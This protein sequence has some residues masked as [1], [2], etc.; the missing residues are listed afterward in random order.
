MTWY[1]RKN[2][3]YGNNDKLPPCRYGF[4]HR[5]KLELAVCEMLWLHEKAGEW[6]HLGHEVCIYLTLARHKY[7]A[8][9]HARDLKTGQD[10]YLEA[11]GFANARWPTTVKLY[12]FYG[13]APL[14]VWKGTWKRPVLVEVITPVKQ[15]EDRE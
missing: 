1:R 15:E 3:K 6:E 10:F 9:F 5:S 12:R 13:P 7:V 4:S 11:K 14:H 8:D 2:S